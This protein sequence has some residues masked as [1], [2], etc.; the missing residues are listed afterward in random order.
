MTPDRSVERP[1]AQPAASVN[2][3]PRAHTTPHIKRSSSSRTPT[4]ADPPD[5]EAAHKP[6]ELNQ[7]TLQY[8]RQ[9]KTA[10]TELLND[11]R[12]TRGSQGSRCLQNILMEA[13]RDLKANRRESLNMHRAN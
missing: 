7:E 1:R 9:M 4:T 11:A 2:T 8:N 5:A 6:H 3:L 12:V 13:E 10:V